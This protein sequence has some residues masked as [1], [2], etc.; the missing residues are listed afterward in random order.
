MGR[1]LQ[2]KN[3]EEYSLTYGENYL[4]ITM[5]KLLSGKDVNL[6][7]ATAEHCRN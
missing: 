5:L 3:G 6:D 7:N 2:G 4:M 1:G